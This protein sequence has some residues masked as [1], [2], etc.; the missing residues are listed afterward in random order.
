M[1]RALSEKALLNLIKKELR[2]EIGKQFELN[3]FNVETLKTEHINGITYDV[4][5]YIKGD[6]NQLFDMEISEILLFYNADILHTIHYDIEKDNFNYLKNKINSY[7]PSNI[8]LNILIK[9][10]VKKAT[11][12]LNDKTIIIKTQKNKQKTKLIIL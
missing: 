11:Y 9:R 6:Y 7:L 8:N 4:Y 2:F 1:K 3:E 10:S 12:K 5:R